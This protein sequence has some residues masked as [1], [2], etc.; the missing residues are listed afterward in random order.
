MA[1]PYHRY[2][3]SK[4]DLHEGVILLQLPES[5]TFSVSYANEGN[6]YLNSTGA[7]KFK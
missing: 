5:F 4:G 7:S 1:Y 3:V 2:L 6:C